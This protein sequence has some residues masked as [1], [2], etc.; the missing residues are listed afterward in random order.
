MRTVVHK[1]EL[2]K[3]LQSAQKQGLSIGFVPTMG[4][5][6]EGHLSLARRSKKENALTV[7]SIFVNPT[8]FGPNE[9]FDR[10]PRDLQHDQ[11]LLS[12]EKI[13]YIYAPETGDIYPAGFSTFVEETEL[14]KVLCG[15]FRPGHFRGVCTVVF[16]LFR[17]V[18]P[19]RAYFGQKD[20][21][22]LRIIEKMTEDLDLEIQIVGCPILRE[23]DGLA[24]SSRNIYLS[25]EERVI[26]PQIHA[27][28]Q[29]AQAA[30]T[31]GERD[32]HNLLEMAK[33]VLAP[34]PAIETQYLELRRWR[35]FG[36]EEKTTEKSVLAFAGHLGKTR[37][38]DNVILIP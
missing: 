10:Y 1:E 30:F 13:D 33:S 17:I 5:L 15:V 23:K 16:R 36:V 12:R 31:Q 6:H 34:F 3:L 2:S 27:A 14:S 7:V 4:A 37:L 24:M 28:L 22:Q 11:E 25:G 35:D 32:T 19:D 38:I 29:K 8:Q 20:A 21:Q 18:R 26:A 9:D